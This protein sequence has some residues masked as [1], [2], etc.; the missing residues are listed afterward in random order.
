MS[1]AQRLGL[2]NLLATA[3]LML[4]S[5]ATAL[6]LSRVFSDWDYLRP[7][8]AV[9][10]AMH[11]VCL[12]LRRLPLPSPI[13]L[14]L[15]VVLL[16]EV[17]AL[18]YYRDTLRFGFPT[19]TTWQYLRADL[20]LVWA[21]FPTAVAPVPS[22]SAFGVVAGAALGAVALLA[23]S[24]AFRALGRTEA[25]VPSAVVFVF[26][27]ALGVDRHRIALTALWLAAALA[28]V[29]VLRV[30]HGASSDGW[31]GRR[32]SSPSALPAAAACAAVCALGAA[33]VG[34]LLPGAGR[35]AIIET[36]Q[37]ATD[38]GAVLSPLVDIRA[39]LVNRSNVEMFTVSAAAGRYW[40]I[41]GLDDFDGTTW[42]LT[43]DELVAADGVFDPPSTAAEIMVQSLTIGRL[44]GRFIPS[45]YRPVQIS[46]PG[47]GWQQST[48]SLLR[49]DSPLASGQVYNIAADIAVPSPAVLDQATVDAPPDANLLRLPDDFPEE[50]VD[51]AEEVVK[52]TTTPYAEALALQSFFRQSFEYDLDVQRGHNDDALVS[53]LRERR[54]Y[55]EQFSA[56]FAAMGRAVGLPT[57]VAV[58]FT[59]GELRSDGFFH[60]L[61]R[62]AHAWPEVWF[63]GVG[64][65]LFEP[66][67][68]RG[69]PGSESVTGVPAAQDTG[70]AA[71]AEQPNASTTL[72]PTTT[73]PTATTLPTRPT[74]TTTPPTLPPL[75][76]G[77]GSSRPGPFGIA[78]LAAAALAL[79]AIA[80]PSLVRRFTRVGDTPAAQVVSAWHGAVAAAEWAGASSPRGAT[81]LEYARRVEHEL[82][83]DGRPITELARFVTRAVY[84]PSGVAEP[85]ALRAA[86]LRTQV[87][88]ATDEVMPRWRRWRCR[89]DPRAVR[90]RLVGRQRV[91]GRRRVS[92]ASR[93]RGAG[94]AAPTPV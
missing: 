34:P 9:A 93:S 84:A 3:L 70:T 19:D 7:V 71:D 2:D 61:G 36:R 57:R 18:V 49:L 33:L 75:S 52:G 17:T 30:V 51:L 21:Q 69:A 8:L 50:V 67:P 80:M 91:A 78:V 62:H 85:T 44:G 92:G 88:E 24:F 83:I 32:A 65:V 54:G 41:S 63:D 26:T 58:G 16:A 40:R 68:G 81:P 22:S 13:A 1:R 6:G 79:W 74:A 35:T 31:I 82:G 15:A 94:G 28:V 45:A 39:R 56:A 10:V 4:L 46:Q 42:T 27:A 38:D 64:W 73:R 20:R 14:L 23:D 89:L 59:Q 47:I 29:A 48:N 77:G 66:T 55:C 37:T 12:L 87:I 72:A 60:V 5:I 53:F 86:V 43:A 11:L 25:L 76:A 90:Q